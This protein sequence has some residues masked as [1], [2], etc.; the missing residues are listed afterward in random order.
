MMPPIQLWFSKI[1]VRDSLIDNSTKFNVHNVYWCIN[2]MMWCND[3]R[4]HYYHIST[5]LY[6]LFPPSDRFHWRKE[7][8]I[9]NQSISFVVKTLTSHTL[10]KIVLN[11]AHP[12]KVSDVFF[13]C[14]C[15]SFYLNNNRQKCDRHTDLKKNSTHLQTAISQ[16]LG[17][18][19]V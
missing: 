6:Q 16:S 11:G 15:C 10:L 9:F 18:F 8:V 13:F 14:Y 19:N 17:T 12:F 5:E 3:D 2:F 1:V 7:C 4:K